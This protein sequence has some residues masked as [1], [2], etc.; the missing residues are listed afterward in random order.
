LL[1]FNS[2]HYRI[3]R[4]PQQCAIGTHPTG[5]PVTVMRPRIQMMVWMALL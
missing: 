1:D 2:A 5:E 4:K 3:V